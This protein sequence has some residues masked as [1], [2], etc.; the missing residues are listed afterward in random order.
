MV[1]ISNMR[2]KRHNENIGRQMRKCFQA[3]VYGKKNGINLFDPVQ[4]QRKV[5]QVS[6]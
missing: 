1:K 6:V 2:W 3:S 5:W 4:G